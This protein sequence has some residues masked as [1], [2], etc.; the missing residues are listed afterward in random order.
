MENIFN[1]KEIKI[2]NEKLCKLYSITY[3][4]IY[5]S[6]LVFFIC[7]YKNMINIK[8]I[9]DILCGAKSNNFRKVIKIYTYKLFFNFFNRNWNEMNSYDFKKHQIDIFNDLFENVDIYINKENKT[10]LTY[11]F[12]PLYSENDYKNYLRKKIDF[13]NKEENNFQINNN[14]I[15]IDIKEDGIDIFL[16]LLI[17]KIFSNLDF[18]N[19]LEDNPK[20]KD[21]LSKCNSVLADNCTSINYEKQLNLNRLLMLFFNIEIYN[22]KIKSK[23][24]NEKNS[25][26]P[27]LME[28]ILYGFRFCAQTLEYSLENENFYSLLFKDNCF[29]NLER[30]YVPGNDYVDNKKLNSLVNIE[31]H[32]LNYPD[33]NGCYVCSCGFYYSI[34]PCGFPTEGHNKKVIDIGGNHGMVI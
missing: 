15:F 20:Y 18:I 28:I 10:F 5:L 3:I 30:S 13:E 33:D 23:I 9:I 29:E 2:E 6:R 32:L 27:E 24:V 11:Y 17:N 7:N 4:K 26:N 22:K 21:Y 34:D 12:L 19:Y 14:E 1:N 8:P 16:C 25:F 31:E